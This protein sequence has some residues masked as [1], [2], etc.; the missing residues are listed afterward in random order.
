MGWGR[1][2]VGTCSEVEDYKRDNTGGPRGQLAVHPAVA[3]HLASLTMPF[4][5]LK[6]RESVVKSRF[7]LLK[8]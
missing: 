2:D 7:R 3:Q 1:S 6:V 5:G 8:G 4:H